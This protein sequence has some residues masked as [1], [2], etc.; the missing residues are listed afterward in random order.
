MTQDNKQSWFKIIEL[1]IML[2]AVIGTGIAVATTLK[3]DLEVVKAEVL[4]IK[5]EQYDLR[6]VVYDTKGDVDNLKGQHGV[7]TVPNDKK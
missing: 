5:A 4:N 1:V 6:R 7:M 3:S 2:V